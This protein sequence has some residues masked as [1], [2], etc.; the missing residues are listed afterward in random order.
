M[1]DANTMI[2]E[3]SITNIIEK[4]KGRGDSKIGFLGIKSLLHLSRY[5]NRLFSRNIINA[6]K[7]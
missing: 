3:R 7:D 6:L 2:Y 4:R 1:N 5:G